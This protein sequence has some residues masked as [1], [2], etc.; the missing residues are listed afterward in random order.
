MGLGVLD[1]HSFERET[2]DETDS[3]DVIVFF[4]NPNL[5]SYLSIYTPKGN[6]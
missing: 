3:D 5:S 4:S 2:G 1:E 6:P